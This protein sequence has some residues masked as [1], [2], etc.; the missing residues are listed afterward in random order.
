MYE[1][2]QSVNHLM[3]FFFL[4]EGMVVPDGLQGT[5]PDLNV[6]QIQVLDISKQIFK[7]I[8]HPKILILSFTTHAHVVPNP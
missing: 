7:G 2:A 3:H 5:T 6:E 8:V 1:T 4:Y